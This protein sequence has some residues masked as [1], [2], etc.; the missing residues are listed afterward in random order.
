MCK[1]RCRQSQNHGW[2]QA[3]K[4]Q[5][6]CPVSGLMFLSYPWDFHGLQFHCLWPLQLLLWGSGHFHPLREL[7]LE[8]L[9]GMLPGSTHHRCFL[10]LHFLPLCAPLPPTQLQNLHAHQTHQK[11]Y[12]SLKS[13]PWQCIAGC[14]VYVLCLFLLLFTARTKTHT[15][16]IFIILEK[17]DHS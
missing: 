1:Q 17:W 2:P 9:H 14:M 15:N 16:D 6:C 11:K 3:L 5:D 12:R 7:T 4:L 8:P 10:K 13:H